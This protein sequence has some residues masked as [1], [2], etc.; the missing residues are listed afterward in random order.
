MTAE[1]L[2]IWDR[3]FNRYRREI[4]SQGEETWNR[5]DEYTGQKIPDGQFK[6]NYVMYKIVDR[7]T[8]SERLEKEYLE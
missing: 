2:N 8:G 1:K 5:R 3:I 7:V 6:R 4:H